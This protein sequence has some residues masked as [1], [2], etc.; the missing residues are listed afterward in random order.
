[1]EAWLITLFSGLSSSTGFRHI[2]NFS[3][4]SWSCYIWEKWFKS[5]PR[6]C[7]C[8][9][10]SHIPTCILWNRIVLLNLPISIFLFKFSVAACVCNAC[11]NQ[12]SM[13]FFFSFKLKTNVLLGDFFSPEFDCMEVWETSSDTHIKRGHFGAVVLNL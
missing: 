1:M 13:I 7:L 6:L 4:P 3:G 2:R 8:L 11:P 9:L 5:L 10:T 12:L